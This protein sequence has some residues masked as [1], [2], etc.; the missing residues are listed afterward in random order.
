MWWGTALPGASGVSATPPAIP[1]RKRLSTAS[2]TRSVRANFSS[3]PSASRKVVGSPVAGPEPMEVSW[4]PITSE[5]TSAA[6]RPGGSRGMRPPPLTAERCLRTVLISWM[7]APHASSR[8]LTRDL[9]SRVIPAAGATSSA[10]APPVSST[11]TR[12]S[13]PTRLR[14][15]SNRVVASTELR[16]GTGCPASSTTTPGTSSR[17]PCFT[18]IRPRTVSPASRRWTPRA[19]AAAAL[20][21]PN[22]KIG[23]PL[24]RAGGNRGRPRKV[25][26]EA[27][28]PRR[29]RSR[30]RS[31]SAARSA[32]R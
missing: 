11:S 13:R 21:A 25:H 29:S 30:I 27:A 16:S 28:S 32:A 9:S 1:S 22:R 18:M 17:C 24:L 6:A 3:T 31:G 5:I 12:L 20:P 19:S 10:D 4:S 2:G 8:E 7:S 26:P 14:S 23:S 15:S